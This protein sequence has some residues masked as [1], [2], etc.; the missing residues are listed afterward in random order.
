VIETVF[1]IPG[2]GQM[3]LAGIT[4]RDYLVVQAAVLVISIITIG[5][6]AAVECGYALIDP[7]IK[8]SIRR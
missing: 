6:N 7:R 4:D 8:G 3:I 2:I 1:N 5:S